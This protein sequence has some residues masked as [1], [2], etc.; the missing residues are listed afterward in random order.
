MRSIY[1]SFLLL[2]LPNMRPK[3]ARRDA[4]RAVTSRSGDFSRSRASQAKRQ[5]RAR[6][7]R[8]SGEQVSTAVFSSVRPQLT[9]TRP[10]SAL[11]QVSFA[12][13]DAAFTRT[14]S[15]ELFWHRARLHFQNAFVANGRRHDI[16]H[17]CHVY[18]RLWFSRDL[19]IAGHRLGALLDPHFPHEN[20]AEFKLCRSCSLACAKNKIPLLSR[21]NGYAFPAMPPDLPKLDKI[22]GRLISSRVLWD[23]SDVSRDIKIQS[24]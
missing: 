22:A 15:C 23:E 4:F 12:S 19:R 1:F 18:D 13:D 10:T 17:K 21:S 24:M 9:I 7:R 6:A 3:V 11:P 2:R 5:T 20:T 16:G 14:P 8:R